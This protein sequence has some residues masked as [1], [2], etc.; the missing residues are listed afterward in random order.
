M[1][2][3]MVGTGVIG[4]IYGCALSKM[5]TIT[6]YVRE[7]KLELFQNKTIPYDIIDERMGKKEQNTTGSY[8]YHCV[9]EASDA[10]DLI[11]VP[12]K[13]QHLIGLLQTLT[14]QA[15]HTN[16]LIF[17][18]DWDYV[19]SIEKLVRKDKYIM[20]YAGGGGTFKDNLLWG[21]IGNDIMLGAAYE[22]QKPLLE[23]VTEAIT[24]C[25]IIPEVPANP[26]H[27]LWIHNVGSAPLAPALNIYAGMMEL[28]QDKALVKIAFKAMR[29]CYQICE[30]RGVDLKKYGEVKMISMP[31]F[32]LYPMFKMNFTKNPV[33]QRYTAHAKDSL[34]EMLYNFKQIYKTGQSLGVIMPNMDY[35]NELIPS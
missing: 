9:A 4:T 10:Y 15:P 3:L 17:T 16:Y 25:G 27:W 29:E 21:N 18:L 19:D 30:K 24:A 6:H 2:I 26:V 8:T 1:N 5:H 23:T 28:I 32:L 12:V 20:G 11:M 31:L 33:M 14:K 34:D 7:E 22:E 35:S 13:N